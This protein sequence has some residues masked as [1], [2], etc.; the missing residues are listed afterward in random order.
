MSIRYIGSKARIATDII[1][2]IGAPNNADGFFID[3]FAGTGIV[4]QAAASCGWKVRLND[5]LYS[6]SILSS[7]RLLGS[8]NLDFSELGG[9]GAAIRALNSIAPEEGFISRSYSPAAKNYCGEERRYFTEDNARHIDSARKTIGIW[10]DEGKI[11]ESELTILL[12]DL[13]EAANHVANTAGTYGCFLST[14]NSN[15][16]KP[17][18]IRQRRIP[19]VGATFERY[20]CDVLD[21]PSS[22]N[23]IAYLDPPYTK[24]QYASYYHILETIAYGDSPKIAGVAGL[25]PWKSKASDYCYKTKALNALIHCVNSTQAKRVYLSYSSQGHVELGKLVDGLSRLGPTE[26]VWRG[27]IGRYRPNKTASEQGGLVS[28]YLI[29]VQKATSSVARD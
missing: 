28:E 13:M 20:N 7:A 6:A 23:D 3:G 12:A 29:S 24:R 17:M 18:K 19:S 10:K 2:E 25:R 21:V 22:S 8:D 9:Y 1:E 14:W 26:V 11:G 4:S 16:K 15:A 27:D 5:S